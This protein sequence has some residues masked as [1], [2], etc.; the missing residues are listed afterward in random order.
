MIDG[1][2]DSQTDRHTDIW[3]VKC[4]APGCHDGRNKCSSIYTHV[5][6]L[7]RE[8]R[9]K[10]IIIKIKYNHKMRTVRSLSRAVRWGR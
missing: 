1:W 3:Q 8:T 4:Q 9:I 7:A 6:D 2:I 10:Y 5:A